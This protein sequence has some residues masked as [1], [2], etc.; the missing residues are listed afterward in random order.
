M[1][2]FALGHFSQL[3]CQLLSHYFGEVVAQVGLYLFR[4][5]NRPMFEIPGA[6]GL[7]MIEV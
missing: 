2:T 7:S 4:R 3:C 1:P 5:G 6:T